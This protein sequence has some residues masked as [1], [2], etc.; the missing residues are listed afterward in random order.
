MMVRHMEEVLVLEGVLVVDMAVEMDSVS[1]GE[2][3]IVE[4]II[5]NR[6]PRR[7]RRFFWRM[8]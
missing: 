1:V 4:V 8:S 2:P 7:M 5:L 3:G 6:V